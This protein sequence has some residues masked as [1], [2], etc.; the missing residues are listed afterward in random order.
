MKS[1]SDSTHQVN[2]TGVQK[3]LLITLYA[4]ALDSRSKHSILHDDKAYEIVKS[5]DY[6]FDSSRGFGN[7]N[8]IVVRAKQ[9]DEWTK[10]FLALHPDSIVLN[11]G[12]GLDSRV[13][14]IRPLFPK[15]GWYDVDYPEVIKERMAFFSDEPGYQMVASSITDSAWLDQLPRD[16]P[17]VVV[18]DGVLEYLSE[19]E[20]KSLLGRLTDHFLSGQ[21]SFDV[22][23]SYA[24]EQGR[25]R[26]KEAFGA[27]HRWA[28]DD[29]RSVDA[30]DPKLRR[31]AA[32]SLFSSK[33]ISAL[34]FRYRFMY[35]L[36]RLFPNF[37]NMIRLLKYDF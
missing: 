28:V 34:E 33:Y 23:N 29:P 15:V 5:L 31:L 3:T 30:L 11:L 25:A 19:T 32:M 17:V 10:E 7:R 16:R 1:D 12:C 22:M 18:A 8:I 4:K 24:Q 35:G 2:L 26:L 21:I 14:R 13:E 9:L 27:E 36:V 20:V 37:K 6:N